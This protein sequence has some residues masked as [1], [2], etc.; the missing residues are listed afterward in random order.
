[1][2]DLIVTSSKLVP[3]FRC[4]TCAAAG[5]GVIDAVGDAFVE[6]ADL[7]VSIEIRCPRCHAALGEI[8]LECEAP[9]NGRYAYD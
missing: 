9:E 3:G 4:P 7:H 2:S 1:M 6:D 8:N 5:F